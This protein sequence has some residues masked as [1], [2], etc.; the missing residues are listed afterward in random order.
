MNPCTLDEARA[1]KKH[2]VAVFGA[3]AEVVAVGITRIDNGYG[4]KVNLQEMPAGEAFLP[5]EVDGVPGRIEVV[6]K[7][8]KA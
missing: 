5:N 3:L 1:A 8:K 7:F 2:A 4:L 6:G